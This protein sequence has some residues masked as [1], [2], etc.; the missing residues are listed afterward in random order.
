MEKC[1]GWKIQR[2]RIEKMYQKVQVDF[3]DGI[4]I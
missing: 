1:V 4:A 2:S 3:F